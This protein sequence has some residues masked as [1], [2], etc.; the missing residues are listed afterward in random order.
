MAKD[1]KRKFNLDNRKKLSEKIKNIDDKNILINIFKIVNRDI[2]N[3]FS[4]NKSGIFFNIN[5]LSDNAVQ[6]IKDLI[7]PYQDTESES[8]IEKNKI[9]YQKYSE[10]DELEIYNTVGYRLS[11]QEKNILKQ[12]KKQ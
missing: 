11:N 2:G 10:P 5:L 4:Q 3:K 1:S 8:V 6:E 9:S 7:K 12:V